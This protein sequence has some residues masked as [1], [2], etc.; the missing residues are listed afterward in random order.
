MLLVYR[1]TMDSYILFYI[2]QLY[3]IHV[4][5]PKAFCGYL[6]GCPRIVSWRLPTVTILLLPFQFG[7]L[8]FLFSLWLMWPGPPILCWIKVVRVTR[9]SYSVPNLRE[10]TL[11]LLNMMLAVGLSYAAFI[12]LRSVPSISTLLRFFIING[13][14]ILSSFP[15]IYWGSHM[16]FIFQLLMCYHINWFTIIELFLHP[17]NKSQLIMV[18]DLFNV[19]NL[20]CKHFVEDFCIYVHP[21][22]WTVIF[23][24]VISLSGLISEWWRL[25]EWGQSFPSSSFFV[26]G[27]DILKIVVNSSLNVW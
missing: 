6:W 4:L 2:Q 22:Y 17:W 11:S 21:W 23:V 8:S 13:S 16:I 19:L 27:G 25:T 7:F 12:M 14:W 24:C 26:V 3:W 20:A 15:H 18:Y 1:T 10:N 5:V 9:H